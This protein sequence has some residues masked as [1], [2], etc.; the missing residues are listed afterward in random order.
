[1]IDGQVFLGYYAWS[2]RQE[3]KQSENFLKIFNSL[4]LG[5]E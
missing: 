4:F 2:A 3:E 5:F 1:M